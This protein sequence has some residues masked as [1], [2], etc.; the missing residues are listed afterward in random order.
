MYRTATTELL[1]GMQACVN[2][3]CANYSERQACLQNL[4]VGCTI[5]GLNPAVDALCSRMDECGTDASYDE[6]VYYYNQVI[7]CYS[8]KTQA[9]MLSCSSTGTCETFSMAFGQCM[10]TQLGLIECYPDDY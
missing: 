3:P 5:S 2:I 8:A 4:L 6:C 9:A 7:D 1:Q 10:N